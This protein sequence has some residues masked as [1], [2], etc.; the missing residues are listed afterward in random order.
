LSSYVASRC[1]ALAPQSDAKQNFY[2]TVYYITFNSN[3]EAQR[4]SKN[5]KKITEDRVR[6]QK[7]CMSDLSV[8]FLLFKGGKYV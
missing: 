7:Q 2:C 3:C 1:L 5:L 8:I 6:S 4:A